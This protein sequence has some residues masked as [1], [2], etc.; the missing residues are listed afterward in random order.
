M[1]D[2][3]NLKKIDKYLGM[4]DKKVALLSRLN[5]TNAAAE[6]RRFLYAYTK[7]RAYNPVFRYKPVNTD[8]NKLCGQLTSLDITVP[9]ERNER[10]FFSKHLENKRKRILKKIICVQHRGYPELSK[11]SLKI[12]GRPNMAQIEYA[13]SQFHPASCSAFYSIKDTLSD[14]E[15]A[16]ML[17]SYA[18]VH[19]VPW[20]V[21][22]RKTISSKAGL[23]SRSKSLLIKTGE[24]FSPEEIDSLAVHEIETHIFRKENGILQNFPFLFGEGFAGPPTTEEGLAFFNETQV[25]HDPRRILLISARTIATHLALKKSF[26]EVFQGLHGLGLPLPYAW[27]VTLRV[28]RGLGDTA[29]PGAFTKDHHYLKG[30]LDVKKFVDSG[31]DIRLLYT[32]KLNIANAEPLK[33]IGIETKEPRYLPRYIVDN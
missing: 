19:N 10:W 28:K 26:H 27:N 2:L 9:T 3:K 4:A 20:K 16:K 30:Y 15:A 32:G 17:A 1:D 25:K 11:H 21:K 13:K 6:K 14:I 29:K 23:D 22:L 12:F 7:N 31:G 33:E 24:R 18:V 8:L 5:P